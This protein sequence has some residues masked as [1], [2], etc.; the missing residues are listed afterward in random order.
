MKQIII[1]ARSAV[2]D[3]EMDVLEAQVE[4]LQELAKKKGYRV[5]QVIKEYGSGLDKTRRG[6]VQLLFAVKSGK[7]EVILCSDFSRLT[8]DMN[9]GLEINQLFRNQRVKVVTL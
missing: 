6:L 1:Y 5:D 2:Q 4:Q 8:R 3:Q 7:V 9:F